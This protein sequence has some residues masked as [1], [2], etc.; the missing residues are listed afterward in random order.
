MKR[1]QLQRI[2]ENQEQQKHYRYYKRLET[3]ADHENSM[4]R[5]KKAEG[6]YLKAADERKKFA[7]KY[8]EGNWDEGHE[9]KYHSIQGKAWQAREA[10][11]K[12]KTEGG[13]GPKPNVYNLWR[14]CSWRDKKPEF[15]DIKARYRP[16][17]LTDYARSIRMKKHTNQ[18]K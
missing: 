5:F 6:L 12:E 1:A 4:G 10:Y 2:M 18:K 9:A 7:E 3:L 15:D 13:E 16:R 11:E 8:F 14:D 17:S